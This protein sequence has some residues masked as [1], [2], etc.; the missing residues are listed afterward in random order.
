MLTLRGPVPLVR[1]FSLVPQTEHD[2]EEQEIRALWS[3]REPT[4]WSDLEKKFRCVILAGAGAGKTHEMMARAELSQKRGRPAF[5]IRIEDI[6]ENFEHSFEVGDLDSFERWLTSPDE[7]WFFLD[8]IDEAR[9]ANPR[10][11]EKAVRRFAARIKH[12][13]HRAHIIISSRPY[14]WRAYTDRVLLDRHLP[15]D[16]PRAEEAG[17]DDAEIE[18]II[19]ASASEPGSALDVYLLNGLDETDIRTFAEHRR[20]ENIDALVEALQRTNLMEVASRPFDL[21]GILAKW[22]ADQTLG[23]R[24]E[25]LQHSIEVLL[26]EI[27]PTRAL[28]QPLNRNA[29][30]AGARTLAAAVVLTGEP[31]IRVPEAAPADSGIDAEAVLA[32]WDPRDIHVLL[33]RGIFNDVLYGV[34]RFRHREVRELLAAEWFAEH[35]QVGNARHAVEALIFREQYGHRIIAPRLRPLLPWLI[36]FDD[37][38]RRTAMSISPEIAVEGGDVARLPFPA[39]QELLQEIVGRIAR[40]EDTRSAR[41]N[42]AI[43]RIAQTDLTENTLRLIKDFA[44]NDEALFFLGRLV[45]Q[46]E[47]TGCLPA[48]S[49]IARS[50]VRGL[51]ARIAAVRA[52]MT[53]GTQQ[54]KRALWNALLALPIELPRQLLSELT[55]GADADRRSVE[56]LLASIEKL[57]P[58]DQFQATGLTGALDDLI[59]RLPLDPSKDGGPL[60]ALVRGLNSFLNREPFIERREC[61]VSQEF[62]W[63]LG[64]A[65]HAV[66]RLV[67]ARAPQAL[68]ADAMAI[69]QKLPV[70]RFWHQADLGSYKDRLGD[71]VPE[72]PD[73][74]DALFWSSIEAARVQHEKKGERLTD[75]WP[76]QFMEHYWC[77]DSSSF[78]RVLSSFADRSLEDDR[79]VAVSLAFRLIKQ[80]D[81]PQ[82]A[83]DALCAKVRGEKALEDRLE[84]LSSTQTSKQARVWRAKEE[85]R[86]LKLERKQKLEKEYRRRWI[87]R[88][89]ANP[90]TV[91]RPPSLEPGQMTNDQYCL[92][93]SI[94]K[95][96]VNS[97]RYA[98]AN[99]RSLASEFGEEVARTFR[100]A[101]MAHWRSYTPELRSEGVTSDGIPY[102]LIFGLTGLEIEAAEVEEFPNHLTPEEFSHALRY[103]TWELNGFP[104]WLERAYRARPHPVFKA[105]LQELLWE[106][107]NA[108]P[109]Q[110]SHYVLHDVVYHAP[111]LHEKLVDPLIDWLG[112][113]IV[114]SDKLLQHA[115]YVLTS[116]GADAAKLVALARSKTE[117]G[118]A[119]LELSD[120]LALW[121]G[122][123]A[124][125]GLPA[126]EGWLSSK[127][128]DEASRLAQLFVTALMG[129]RHGRQIGPGLESY[130]TAPRLKSL[131]VLMHRHIRV[132]EDIERSGKGVYSPG[133]RDD[134]QDARNRIFNYLSELPGKAT[135][136]ALCELMRDHPNPAARTWMAVQALRRAERDGDIE[137]WSAQQVRE[138]DQ[139]QARTPASNRQ[140]FD[141]T[142]DRLTDMRNWLE[143]GNDSPYRTWQK[144][145]DETEMRNLVAG[146]LN[147]RAAARYTCAQENELPNKQRPD[148]WVQSPIVRS[149]IPI[150]IKLLDKGWTGPK[151]CE[152]LRNQLAGDYLREQEGGAG[153]MLLFWQG[154]SAGR[155][156]RIG[157]RGVGL[158]GLE[159]ALQEYWNGI[160]HGF[161][162]VVA[163]KVIVIDLMRRELRSAEA[164][165][166]L[167]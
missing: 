70:A 98:G 45:W 80:L 116:G 113:N 38:I 77:F 59:D 117:G 29:A 9:L 10:A 155:R 120:W 84:T 74:N 18:G 137:P 135:Y 20:T 118:S 48:L 55:Q 158:A 47:M 49:E 156:W 39:R 16:R 67:A 85:K 141:L 12:A 148:I 123:D 121:V 166:F 96:G 5:F 161:P 65:C 40:S 91:R 34:V 37:D 63:L 41:D 143:R 7:A 51:Y 105:L 152:R 79:L 115:L 110:P 36:L 108:G 22:H 88:L 6:D 46:G 124:E 111:W 82:A 69:M 68:Q 99:W 151:L 64:P 114:L 142:V 101:A 15:F 145:E 131:Y 104:S 125:T 25:F 146:R 3:G 21:E 43:A 81:L 119:P 14:A 1:R 132:S 30:R 139:G 95:D 97:N 94:E 58:Y 106:L 136:V 86:R 159:G 42:D 128:A 147:E 60:A 17:D 109:E 149:P 93:R 83:Q 167:S 163:V 100:D 127:E 35:L 13:Q 61:R 4:V 24:L 52:V 66:T 154:R 28:Q 134:A 129:E 75:D 126:L 164:D 72:W 11:F 33:E 56:M 90:E 160:S 138:F 130:R 71:L 133:L 112:S 122:A 54:Q 50:P 87:E 76:V 103:V 57:P 157:G 44:D 26:N 144:A 32:D 107:D 150:E 73:L 31:G 78:D 92:L 89:R 19:E 140:L 8:S 153:V 162:N 53:T 2:A 102:T 165:A 27:D 23:G 62:A